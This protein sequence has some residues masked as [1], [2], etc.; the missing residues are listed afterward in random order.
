MLLKTTLSHPGAIFISSFKLGDDPELEGAL[1]LDAGTDGPQAI[2]ALKKLLALGPKE[3]PQVLVEEQIGDAT[4]FRPKEFVSKAGGEL[5][6]GY[7]GS[8]LIV[9]FGKVTAKTLVAKLSEIPATHCLTGSY[10]Q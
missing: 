4:F 3:G 7:R 9:A 10:G 5:R 6:I 2:E 8:Q 1:V